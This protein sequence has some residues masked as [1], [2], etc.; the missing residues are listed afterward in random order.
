MHPA[1]PGVGFE[2][3]YKKADIYSLLFL[4]SFAAM[5]SGCSLWG[6]NSKEKGLTPEERMRSSRTMNEKELTVEEKKRL[7]QYE[8]AYKAALAKSRSN[9]IKKGTG[10]NSLKIACDYSGGARGCQLIYFSNRTRNLIRRTPIRQMLSNN[11]TTGIRNSMEEYFDSEVDQNLKAD[12]HCAMLK[13]QTPP[14]P[15]ENKEFCEP[16]NIKK[17]SQF[18]IEPQIKSYYL[19]LLSSDVSKFSDSPEWYATV[20][21]RYMIYSAY[22]ACHFTH[23]ESG[24]ITKLS[25]RRSQNLIQSS[26]KNWLILQRLEGAV[27]PI[28]A[29]KNFS[30]SIYCFTKSEKPN[31]MYQFS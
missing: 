11:E 2:L 5:V 22:S 25:P 12:V 19:T 3:N 31:C 30:V 15:D 14:Y 28:D 7:K 20:D 17:F 13:S 26:K 27:G 18:E 6:S 16:A 29:P 9:I 8:E 10:E 4:F 21:C 23:K 24:A 1:K